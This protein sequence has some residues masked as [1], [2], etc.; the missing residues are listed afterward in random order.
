M[1]TGGSS[2]GGA[3]GA[4][5]VSMYVVAHPDDELL[6]MNPDLETDVLAGKTVTTVYVT[7]GDGGNPAVVVWP[8]RET[9][10]RTAHAAMAGVADLWT[11]GATAPYAG[12]ALWKCTLNGRPTVRSIYLRVLDGFVSATA[13]SMGTIDGSN[14]FTPAE[15]TATLAAIQNETPP[16]K[17]GTL[18]GSLAHGSDHADHIAVG[19]FML[20]VARAQGVSRQLAM[21]RGYSMAE[22]N[23]AAQVP[24]AE[25]EN[26]STTQYTE[27]LRIV[28]IYQP[29]ALDPN[30]DLWCHRFYP[31]R[32]VPGGPA[33]LKSAA[34]TTQCLQASGTTVGSSVVTATCN[35]SANQSW[36]ASGTSQLIASGGG[37][38]ALNGAAAVIATCSLTAADQKWTLDDDGQL[39]GTGSTC[40]TVTGTAVSSATCT[41]DTSA[42][43][44]KPPTTQHWNF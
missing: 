36:T 12:K 33:P 14:T 16:G 23:F 13:T 27:K 25:A 44:Y 5:S 35:G 22:P 31:L 37:C 20:D 43:L 28:Q 2:S 34:G 8:G 21:Y 26:L 15:L 9:S 17:V 11:C 40:L 4:T 30:F 41:A 7:S 3:G 29:G 42:A 24:A 1:S 6:F 19:Q 39:K 18:D 10:V 32:A 38:L